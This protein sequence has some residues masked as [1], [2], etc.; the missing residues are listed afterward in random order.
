MSKVKVG[1]VGVGNISAAYLNTAKTFPILD[2]VAVADLDVE[3][4]KARA[5]EFGVPKAC[6]VDE[7]INDP[8]IQIVINLTVP[9]AHAPVALQAVNAGKSVYNEKPL[10][11]T[12]EDGRKLVEA[13]KK[14]NVR[15]GCAPGTFLGGG[16]QT[17][18]K[19]IDDGVIGDPVA[20]L[21][22][23]MCPGHESWHPS[24]EFYYEV[25]GGPMMDMGPYYLTAMTN[26]LGPAKRV[27][28]SAKI[29]KPERTITSQPKNGKKITVETPDHISGTIDFA[30]G[31]VGTIV[32]SFAT[33]HSVLPR[34]E[35]HGTKGSLQ[36]PDPNSLGG[37]V[38]L[39][40]AG[41][42]EWKDVAL[43]HGHD[44]PNRW[45]IG[46]ADMAFAIRSNRPHRATGQNAL[47]V[48][49]IMHGFLT[50]SDSGKHVE[51]KSEFVRPKALPTGLPD[52]ALD[53]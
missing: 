11:V 2:V 30:S 14:K 48:L 23:M 13:A 51:I 10:T 27:S 16:L 6:G 21:A 9:K 29:L 28:G 43:T 31:A 36:C 47:H 4:A 44:G 25:G 53:E 41:E 12:L 38:K 49:E 37:P 46:V 32:T 3:R 24:P 15:I 34:I 7:L 20:A 39:R 45:G 8:S 40:L 17:C 26:L 33:Y 35:I 5:T 18:R 52:N 50:S 42:K 22:F 19:L 1:I